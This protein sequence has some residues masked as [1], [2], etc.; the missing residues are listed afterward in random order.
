MSSMKQLVVLVAVVALCAVG[1]ANASAAEFTASAT[2]EIE[3]HATANQVF[4]TNGGT[5]TCTKAAITG[6]IEKTADTQQAAIVN[7][8]GCTAFG[9]ATV[10]ISSEKYLFTAFGPVHI[11]ETITV[12]PTLFGA[13]LCTMTIPKQTVSAVDFANSGIANI[14][15]NP[16][17]TGIV[18][19]STGGSCGSSGSNGTYTGSSEIN[20]KGGGT[21]R[22]DP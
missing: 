20:R 11:L 15:E 1:V 17:I 12:T 13:S 4:T 8:S 5:V 10:D 18:Y 14:T 6:K 9:F 7:L 16:T 19:T 3:G 22:F 21:I 2:G